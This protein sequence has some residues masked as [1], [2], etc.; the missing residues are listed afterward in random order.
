[1]KS[2]KVT[3]QAIEIQVVEKTPLIKSG[4]QNYGYYYNFKDS[5]SPILAFLDDLGQRNLVSMLKIERKR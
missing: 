2:E 1:M 4:L 5:L 3:N